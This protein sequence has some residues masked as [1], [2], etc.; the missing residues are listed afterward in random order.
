MEASAFVKGPA[1]HYFSDL[2][3]ACEDH[4]SRIYPDYVDSSDHDTVMCP[5]VFPVWIHRANWSSFGSDSAY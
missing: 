3:Q 2:V 5:E 4:L 1:G